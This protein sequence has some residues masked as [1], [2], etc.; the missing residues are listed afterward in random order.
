MAI[1][2]FTVIPMVEESRINE[3]VETVIEAIKD[4]GLKFEVGANGTTIEGDLDKLFEIIKKS[5]N[6][7][8]DLGSGRVF[9][10]IKI[11]DKVGGITIEEKI[12]KFRK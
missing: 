1:A 4:S 7:A 6:I 5:H 9:T 2:E 11:D 12:S 8:K 10:I 3:I